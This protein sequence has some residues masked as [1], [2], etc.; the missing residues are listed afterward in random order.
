VDAGRRLNYLRHR[1]KANQAFFAG[2]DAEHY[3]VGASVGNAEYVVSQAK[4]YLIAERWLS[5]EPGEPAYRAHVRSDISRILAILHRQSIAHG[6]D[7]IE[8]L[9]EG[10]EYEEAV[11]KDI[12]EGRRERKSHKGLNTQETE[13][14]K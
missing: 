4:D 9:S 5:E 7:F 6:F 13:T 8:L 11:V 10:V 3:G 14:R 2:I 12:N 1:A